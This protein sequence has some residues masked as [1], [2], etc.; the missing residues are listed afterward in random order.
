MMTDPNRPSIKERPMRLIRQPRAGLLTTLTIALAMASAARARAEVPVDL[1]A[2]HDDCGIAVRH[3]GERLSVSWPMGGDEHGR[4]VMDFRPG[5]PVVASMGIAASSAGEAKALLKEVDP[6]WFVTVGSRENPPGRPPSMSVFNVFFDSPATRAHGTFRSKLDLKTVRVASRPGR[7]SV[8]LADLTAGPFSG[9][10]EITV[11][12]GAR[13]VHVEA[14]VSTPEEERAFVYDAGLALASTPPGASLSGCKSF[15]WF[16][17]ERRL[18]RERAD[19]GAVDRPRAVRHRAIVAETEYG[20]VASFPPPHQFFYPRDITD[21]QQTVWSGRGHRGLDDRSGFG[22][23]QS[24]TGGGNFVPWF[25]AP[26]GTSQR[27]GVFYLLSRGKAEEALGEVLKY[28]HGDRFPDLPGYTSFSSHW[29]MAIT[30]DAMKEKASGKVRS[31]PEF[32]K[33]FK[34]MNVKAVHLAEFHGDGHPQDPGPLRLAEMEAMFAECRRLSDGD[35]TFLPGEEANVYLGHTAPGQ[36]AG[37]WLY[38]FPRPVYWTMKRGPDQPF[39]EKDPK[40]GAVYHVGNRDEMVRLLEREHGLAWTAHPR[41]KA[42]NWTPDAY[43]SDDFYLSDVWLGAAWKAMPADLSSPRLGLRVL[44]LLD[45]MANWGQKKYV[46]GE[47]DVFKIDHTHELYGHMNINYLKLDRAPRF[48]G[49]WT[50]LLDTLRAGKFFVT[51]GEVLLT[52]FSVGGKP[53]GASLSLATDARPEVKLTLQ[54]TFPMNF[55][56]VISGDGRKVY[57][58]RIDLSATPAFG[59]KTFTHRPDLAGRRWVRVE[60]WD[61]AANGT[62]SQPVWIEDGKVG[63]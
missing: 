52:S 43:R 53:S 51:T 63:K 18:Q 1:S 59:T 34:D 31:T 37:H 17:T 47:V 20:S 62:F 50:P 39:E 48:E 15:A 61:V 8:T 23:R 54:W 14:V 11:Y 21:N 32:V 46:L 60:A 24:E 36:H 13:L 45:D 6:V 55:A 9:V 33:M 3:Q 19:P 22:V 16:D 35:L 12:A 5:A 29:H 40:Y 56:E 4:L 41:I 49:D 38:L 26:P 7:A 42:S 27:L 25:N 44:D 57:R 28:T 2:F 10:L 58:D 30:V